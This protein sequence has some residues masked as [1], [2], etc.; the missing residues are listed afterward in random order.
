[1]KA[2]STRCRFKPAEELKVA[3]VVAVNTWWTGDVES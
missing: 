1:M 2:L 3:T